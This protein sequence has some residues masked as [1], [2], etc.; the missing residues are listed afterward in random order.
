MLDAFIIIVKNFWKN[1]LK[2]GKN[3]SLVRKRI[4]SEHDYGDI[5]KYI[6]AKI[7]LH[8]DKVNT[9]F[10]SNQTRNENIPCKCLSLIMVDFV[11]KK[12]KKYYSQTV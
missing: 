2:Y 4:D 8:G 9:Q 7:K 12:N 11:I 5:H 6:K 10:Q 3:S 1:T